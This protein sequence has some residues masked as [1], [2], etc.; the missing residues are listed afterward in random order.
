MKFEFAVIVMNDLL[1][2]W[3]PT[4]PGFVHQGANHCTQTRAHL[5]EYVL[6]CPTPL[7]THGN[8][9]GL[10]HQQLYDFKPSC[11]WVKHLDTYSQFL[12]QFF[13]WVCMVQCGPPIVPPTDFL[14]QVL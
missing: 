4:E 8:G 3:V 10:Y 11:C 6:K 7:H 14:S 9:G 12:P 1:K 2:P 13:P 5:V